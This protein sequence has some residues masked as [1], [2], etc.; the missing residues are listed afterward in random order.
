MLSHCRLITPARDLSTTEKSSISPENG[1]RKLQRLRYSCRTMRHHGPPIQ[2]SFGDARRPTAKGKMR[3]SRDGSTSRSPAK[4]LLTGAPNL[5]PPR[6]RR[7]SG[8]AWLYKSTCIV[9]ARATAASSRMRICKGRCG[10]STATASGRK[11]MRSNGTTPFA[12]RM[13]ARC[14]A[15][16]LMP[17]M[18]GWHRTGLMCASILKSGL[19]TASSRS[20]TFRA[21][22][23]RRGKTR[24]TSLTNIRP[25]LPNGANGAA[26]APNEPR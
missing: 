6:P 20:V 10:D 21:P 13:A 24:Q 9:R 7:W 3:K 12:R 5:P 26:S 22:R 8:L 23:S 4:Y 14:G 11:P 19:T 15:V 25:C 17:Q 16:S 18:L 1:E 2:Q